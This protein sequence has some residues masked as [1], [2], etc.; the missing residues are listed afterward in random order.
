[1]TD[2]QI[3]IA[4]LIV[5]L[6]FFIVVPWAAAT[7]SINREEKE[8]QEE[9]NYNR[10]QKYCWNC[11]NRL[12]TTSEAQ[13]DVHTGRPSRYMNKLVCPTCGEVH[14]TWFHYPDRSSK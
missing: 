7:I 13:Y 5:G 3:S 12:V 4:F 6:T 8:R 9:E 2:N 1:M 11:G 14:H 10:S